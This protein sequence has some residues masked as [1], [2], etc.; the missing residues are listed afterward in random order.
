MVKRRLGPEA[1]KEYVKPLLTRNDLLVDITFV[2]ASGGPPGTLVGGPGPKP[3][4]KMMPGLGLGGTI[5]GGGGEMPGE[6]GGYDDGGG[7]GGG[8]GTIAG[9]S[10]I[11][12]GT[13]VPGTGGAPGTVL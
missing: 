2:S 10:P 12:G 8:G 11:G 9:G 7:L 4:G 5:A 6:I 3:G 1:K 13:L